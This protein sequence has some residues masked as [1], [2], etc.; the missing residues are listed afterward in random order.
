[1]SLDTPGLQQLTLSHN[2]SLVVVSVVLMGGCVV[3]QSCFRMLSETSTSTLGS[4]PLLL[5]WL[6]AFT[7]GMSVMFH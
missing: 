5:Y 3:S 4:M 2:I 6:I 7:D 1:M